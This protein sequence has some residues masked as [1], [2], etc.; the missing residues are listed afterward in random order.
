MII[1]LSDDLIEHII[2]KKNSPQESLRR[3]K[4][5]NDIWNS[6][7]NGNHI[8]WGSV[9]LLE[10]LYNQECIS[11]DNK[12]VIEWV[13]RRYSEIAN[14]CEE[15]E[16]KLVVISNGKV[17]AYEEKIVK[18][19][20]ANMS[21]V[22]TTILSAENTRD[23]SLYLS[24]AERFLEDVGL[25]DFI[26]IHVKKHSLFGGNCDNAIEEIFDV[27]D[28]ENPICLAMVDNDKKYESDGEGSTLKSARSAVASRCERYVAHLFELKVREKENMIPP[29]FYKYCNKQNFSMFD[30][31]QKYEVGDAEILKYCDLKEGIFAKEYIKGNEEWHKCYDEFLKECDKRGFLNCTF[32]QIKELEEEQRCMQGVSSKLLDNFEKGILRRGVQVLYEEKKKFREQG[33]YISEEEMEWYKSAADLS[34]HVIKRLPEYLA[35]LWKEVFEVIIGFGCKVNDLE[36]NTIVGNVS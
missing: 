19:P 15:I 36:F 13:L 6:M 18:V 20:F 9:E 29:R 23:A 30:F 16:Y 8:V 1:Q 17:V 2:E 14:F 22:S 21:K 25:N 10:V 11:E 3:R 26:G 35:S 4:I 27:R 5:I 33:V 34:E 32:E 31:M 28:D 24:I 7:A 12:K